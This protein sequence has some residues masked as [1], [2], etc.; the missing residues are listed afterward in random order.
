MSFLALFGLAVAGAAQASSSPADPASLIVGEWEI[1]DDSGKTVQQCGKGQV[2]KASADGRH[3]ELTERGTP[4]WS[5]RYL[6]V[7][8]DLD[9]VLMSIENEERLT[10]QGD[11]ILWWATFEH[12]DKFRWRR[13]DW[14]NTEVTAAVWRRCRPQSARH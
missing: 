14:K 5:V 13:Y 7:R 3:I 4:D 9:R 10:D 6:I 8:R 1:V 12:P 11:P 2:F